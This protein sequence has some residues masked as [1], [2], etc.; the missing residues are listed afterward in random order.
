MDLEIKRQVVHS[1]GV[2]SIL[3]ILIFGSFYA[4]LIMLFIAIALILFGE[5][6]K[7]KLIS[8][9]LKIEPVKELEDVIDDEIKTYERVK[10][11]PLN[12]AVMFFLGSF[13]Y[14]KAE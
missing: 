4:A 12:G 7:N 1:L 2:F 3:L 9:I 13:K 5:Y 10:E 6:R 11:L 8:K 14:F